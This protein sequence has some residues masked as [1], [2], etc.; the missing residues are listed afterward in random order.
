M[1]SGAEQPQYL[2]RILKTVARSDTLRQMLYE[3]DGVER[4]LRD[5]AIAPDAAH[6]APEVRTALVDGNLCKIQE[7][8]DNELR[9]AGEEAAVR[10]YWA[11]VRVV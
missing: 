2:R 6:L 7:A 9:D 1:S 11:L 8:L 5:Q 3:P 4:V 10:P